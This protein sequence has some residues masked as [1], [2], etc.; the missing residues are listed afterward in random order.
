MDATNPTGKAAR[1][2][3]ATAPQTQAATAAPTPA[4]GHPFGP[5]AAAIAATEHWSLLGTRSLIWNE[6]M[7]RTTV[8][9]SVLSAAIVAL[10]L[11]ANATGFRSQTATL[12]LVLLPVVLFVGVA[13]HSRLLQINREDVE[14]VLAWSPRQRGRWHSCSCGQ[15]CTC[16]NVAPWTRGA[17]RRRGSPPRQANTERPAGDPGQ[18]SPGAER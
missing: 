17:V 5:D 11:V 9:L 14:L 1:P 3:R 4:G 18:T 8:F 15:C 16:C 6:A 13:T 10:A 12:A 2:Q 7:S